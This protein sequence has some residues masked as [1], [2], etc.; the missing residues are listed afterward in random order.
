[1]PEAGGDIVGAARDRLADIR[2][3]RIDRTKPAEE[4][5]KEYLEQAGEF[6]RIRCGDYV[7]SFSYAD[8]EKS[9]EERMLEYVSKIAEARFQKSFRTCAEEHWDEE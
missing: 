5:L 6:D 4:R 7:M 3:I 8:T 2:D 9:L 1:M